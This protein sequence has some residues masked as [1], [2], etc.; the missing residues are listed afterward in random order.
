M[1]S[2]V[3]LILLLIAVAGCNSSST[4]QESTTRTAVR[5]TEPIEVASRSTGSGT[6]SIEKSTSEP[7]RRAR[8]ADNSK[9][10][11]ATT[12]G[13][14]K[15]KP[16]AVAPSPTQPAPKAL[17]KNVEAKNGVFTEGDLEISVESGTNREI[18]TRE[19]RILWLEITLKFR[20]KSADQRQDLTDWQARLQQAE[21]VDPKNQIVGRK[22]AYFCGVDGKRMDPPVLP[23]GTTAMAHLDFAF[24]E[25]NFVLNLPGPDPKSM[26]RL[27]LSRRA[28]ANRQSYWVPPERP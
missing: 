20:N 23:P 16:A 26:I 25:Q 11:P 12:A 2:R 10:P 1:L 3:P 19:G 6:R 7:A 21:L 18:T 17:P 15:S 14:S 9:S 8:D 22:E 27:P 5:S 13:E 4:S 28:G 24:E